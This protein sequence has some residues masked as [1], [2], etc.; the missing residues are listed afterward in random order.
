MTIA[1]KNKKFYDDMKVWLDHNLGSQR[2][3]WDKGILY[4]YDV[5]YS[6]KY[7]TCEALKNSCM[8]T[9]LYL[10]R[11]EIDVNFPYFYDKDIMGFYT[12]NWQHMFTLTTGSFAGE[13]FILYDNQAYQM[14]GFFGF[15]YRN[16]PTKGMINRI[17]N[18]Q[19]RKQGKSELFSGFGALITADLTEEDA[20]AEVY[21]SGPGEDSSRILFD[22]AKLLIENS[23]MLKSEF[24][25]EDILKSEIKSKRGG[26]LKA[27]PFNP[28]SLEGHNPSLI[29]F[30]EFHMHPT[31]DMLNSAIS[32]KNKTR[33][34]QKI[35]FDTTKG[36]N[37]G[38]V[39]Y[40]TEMEYKQFTIDQLNNP[41]ELISPNI[42]TFICESDL[43]DDEIKDFETMLRKANP[44]LGITIDIDDL[45]Q[46]WEE[47]RYDPIK[48]NEFRVKRLGVWV[49]DSNAGVT[50]SDLTK[51][52][53]KW[54]SRY[55]NSLEK[56]QDRPAIISVDLAVSSD[57]N[58]VSLLFK[59]KVEELDQ[60]GKEKEIAVFYSKMFV[61]RELLHSKNKTEGVNYAKWHND[62]H[63]ILSGEKTVN[64]AD[65][66]AYIVNLLNTYQ[67]E[68]IRVD[69]YHVPTLLSILTDTYKVEESRFE[70][71]P[72]R[73]Q[74]LSG[75]MNMG[76]KKIS[77]QEFYC[78][79]HEHTYLHFTNMVAS[80][81]QNYLYFAKSKQVRKIDIFA[82][83]IIAMSGW[84]DLRCESLLKQGVEVWKF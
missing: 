30:G 74:I 83:Y 63:V 10:Y 9:L 32:S 14:I 72:Q 81:Y 24:K 75:P 25:E 42:F 66:A 36:Y 19:A 62:G 69:P 45:Y 34:N 11:S 15:K 22:K 60:N 52:N 49:G 55:G 58:V 46:E 4:A 84:T 50:L 6:D 43:W 13:P 53:E 40:E 16:Q 27:L 38:G 64:Y 26:I 68:K 65:I 37:I 39:A 77:D 71:V 3:K 56:F 73:P 61:P 54:K 18:V 17:Y 80:R 12:D 79:G 44:M 8:K 33:P 31:K 2:D 28:K 47:S 59:D 20:N 5:V 48:A 57:L 41:T 35:C 7:V 51:T 21:I 29:I 70:K 67:V 82:T 1:P 76:L 23:E 78:F